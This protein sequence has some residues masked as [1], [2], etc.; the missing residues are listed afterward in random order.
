MFVYIII[1]HLFNDSII[2]AVFSNE[3]AAEEYI[4]ANGEGRLGHYEVCSADVRDSY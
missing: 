4:A 3:A 1:Y 2:E